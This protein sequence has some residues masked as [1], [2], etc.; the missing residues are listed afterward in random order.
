M[1]AMTPNFDPVKC[2]FV[3]DTVSVVSAVAV[4]SVFLNDSKES[5]TILAIPQILLKNT[6]FNRSIDQP[7]GNKVLKM[8]SLNI[9]KFNIN[10]LASG[11]VATTFVWSSG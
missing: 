2:V 9:E 5:S 1:I 8:R 4:K 6:T 3:G 7:H 11:I 10:K